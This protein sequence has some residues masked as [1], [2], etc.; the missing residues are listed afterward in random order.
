MLA[1]GS[2]GDALSSRT[3]SSSLN[4]RSLKFDG[5]PP[6]KLEN[7]HI[8]MQNDLQMLSPTGHR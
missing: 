3:R 5:L 8:N 1:S 4:S 7:L 2:K 6:E